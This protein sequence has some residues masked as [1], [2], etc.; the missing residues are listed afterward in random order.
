MN[1]VPI[2]IA[3]ISQY[4]I[5]KII[6]FEISL[7][8][9]PKESAPVTNSWNKLTIHIGYCYFLMTKTSHTSNWCMPIIFLISG[10]LQWHFACLSTWKSV[11]CDS[12]IVLSL[13]DFEKSNCFAALIFDKRILPYSLRG[14]I[15][16]FRKALA[17][18]GT[19]APGF[20][21]QLVFL[22]FNTWGVMYRCVVQW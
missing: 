7:L 3:A 17:P 18:A 20:N 14:G 6:L 2:T 12:K 1:K 13:T 16:V 15:Q 5:P 4:T 21:H 10:C 8:N 9:C 19:Y 22:I 11:S